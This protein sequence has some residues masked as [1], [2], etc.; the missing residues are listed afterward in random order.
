ME[1]QLQ[2]NFLKIQ[3]KIEEIFGKGELHVKQISDLERYI[4][5][6]S[7]IVKAIAVMKKVN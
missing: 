1:K 5:M 7:D 6:Q 2:E 3:S 4:G